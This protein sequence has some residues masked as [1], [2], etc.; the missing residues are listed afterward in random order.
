ME[1]VVLVQGFGGA[2]LEIRELN[3]RHSGAEKQKAIKDYQDYLDGVWET[4]TGS[5]IKITTIYIIESSENFKSIVGCWEQKY[6][7]NHGYKF[8]N[9]DVEVKQG[10]T[11][12][13]I[14]NLV[15]V[16][17]FEFAVTD[18]PRKIRMEIE[19]FARLKNQNR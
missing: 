17:E 2:N 13:T 10:D 11:L 8:E 16:P 3:N 4:I 5:E 1:K 7:T 12:R 19:Q 9:V 15:S 14:K 6:G 18:L